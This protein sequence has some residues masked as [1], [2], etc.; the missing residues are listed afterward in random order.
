MLDSYY[1]AKYRK[2][3]SRFPVSVYI[4]FA[5]YAASFGP[6]MQLRSVGSHNK[7]RSLLNMWVKYFLLSIIAL[8]CEAVTQKSSLSKLHVKSHITLR[9]AQT[10]VESLIKNPSN[11]SKTA[12]FSILLPESAF[13]SFFSMTKNGK[14]Q[15]SR[16]MAKKDARDSFNSAKNKGLGAGLVSQDDQDANKFTIS[17][18]IE[19]R[20]KVVFKLKYEELLIR[21][22]GQYEHSIN[23][24]PKGLV[25]DLNVE[26]FINESFP[27]ASLSVPELK[28]TNELN[29]NQESDNKN[30]L[31][32]WTE[33]SA[34]ASIK[35]SPDIEEQK[36][37]GESGVEGQFIVKYDVDRKGRDNEVHVIDGYFIHFFA[38]DQLQRLPKHA[39]FVLDISGSMMGR[40]IVQL[41]DAMF[42]ILDEMTEDDFFSIIIFSSDVESWTSFQLE[43]H[44]KDDT[45]TPVVIKAT[46]HNK[47]VAIQYVN[48]LK[49]GGAT[50]INLAMMAGVEVAEMG[51]KEDLLPANAQSMVIFLTDGMPTVGETRSLNIRRNTQEKN[52]NGIPIFSL[53]FGKDA[54]FDL[55]KKISTESDAF[56]RKIY[57]GAD[58]AIQL[59]NFFSLISDPLI[60]D[61]SFKYLGNVVNDSSL[62]K[63]NAKT[64]FRGAEYVVVGKL[65][66]NEQEQ[67]FTIRLLGDKFVGRY[68]EDLKICPELKPRALPQMTK[69]LPA[70]DDPLYSTLFGV[71]C[72]P[73]TKIP[74]SS[75]EHSFM[76]K[77]YAFVTIKQLLKDEKPSARNRA[78]NLALKNNFVTELTSLVVIDNQDS[79]VA[80]SKENV[81]ILDRMPMRR[82]YSSR[83]RGGIV[84]FSLGQSNRHIYRKNVYSTAQTPSQSSPRGGAKSSSALSRT[85]SRARS[86]GNI[87]P[88]SLNHG[89][90]RR[91]SPDRKYSG[92][93][94]MQSLPGPYSSH[95]EVYSLSS[96]AYDSGH[97]KPQPD[98]CNGSIHL[99]SKTYNRGNNVTLTEDTPDL[100]NQ[101][102]SDLLASLSVI[103]DCCWAVFTETYYKGLHQKFTS[104]SS[105][106]TTTSLGPVF[107]R[108]KSVSKC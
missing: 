25:D 41:K 47:N 79:V 39:V 62:S 80:S 20:S 78:L 23:I 106:F 57:E 97:F 34:E 28:H 63:T 42:T 66:D 4:T 48:S 12:E 24:D 98:P 3:Q 69:P 2:T 49:E 56:A 14:E 22:N 86:S 83:S 45:F 71:S 95:S 31:I 18:N 43:N 89:G 50:N 36:A 76:E 61:L 17:T 15:V 16:V 5:T 37:A 64:F 73:P 54:D 93:R 70:L 38:P 104:G 84:P 40:K 55:M 58:A 32:D 99:F 52:V 74:Q 51:P 13:I 105:Y 9:Y 46:Q 94:Y 102:F 21:R 29:F 35:Y 59:E 19:G 88:F 68:Q 101:N 82:T 8:S 44:A 67:D 75:H 87:V 1:Y 85:G 103:G 7:F 91:E 77:L 100:S 92:K 10:E 107:R 53:A 81:N 65:N 60:S 30:A 6:C 27:L 26:V 33:G 96:Q 108:A 72:L 11:S 90:P